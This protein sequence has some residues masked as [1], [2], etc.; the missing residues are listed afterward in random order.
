[1]YENISARLEKEVGKLVPQTTK[2]HVIA[3]KDRK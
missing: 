2:V 1:M 3:Q